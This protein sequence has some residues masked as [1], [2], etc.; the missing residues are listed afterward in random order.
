ML[1][2]IVEEELTWPTYAKYLERLA[3]HCGDFT[4]LKKYF[5]NVPDRASPESTAETLFVYESEDNRLVNL[6]R[7]DLGKPLKPNTTRIIIYQSFSDGE[8]HTE[9]L[10]RISLLYNLSPHFIWSHLLED[11][12][13]DFERP[14]I[15]QSEINWLEL[16]IYKGKISSLVIQPP[17]S[18][19]PLSRLVITLY[20]KV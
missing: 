18:I 2:G 16:E 9:V 7:N 20:P 12:D 17:E 10:D 13:A 6:D 15:A 1:G 19:G 11:G 5:S 8:P 3:S 14:V 4:W